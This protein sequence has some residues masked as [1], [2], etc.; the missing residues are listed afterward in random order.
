MT[1]FDPKATAKLYD[2]IADVY[3]SYYADYAAAVKKQG[4]DL[5][6]II[7]ARVSV[8]KPR[9][10][11]CSCGIGTQAVGLALQ[12]CVVEGCDISPKSVAQAER[13]AAQFGVS[14]LPLRA[15]DMRQ[16]GSLYPENSYDAVI[17]CGNSLAH[18]LEQSDIE[19]VL[20]GA[21]KLLKK[22]G[23]FLAALTDHED[24]EPRREDQFHDPHIKRDGAL[25]TANY[26]IWTWLK[27]GETYVC[28]DYTVIDTADGTTV[29]K[30]SAPFRIWKRAQLFDL[31]KTQGFADAAWLLPAKTGHHNPILCLTA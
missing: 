15:A 31:A 13:H 24:R 21:R 16:I 18:L 9:V 12:G 27:P 4:E 25:K 29:K 17:S 8:E 14:G 10:L 7:R 30:V 6:R 28:D 26:Q 23:V 20:S 2:D 19:A 22:G 5:A 1:S 11:D 3:S